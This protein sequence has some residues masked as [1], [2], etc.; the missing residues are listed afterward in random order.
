MDSDAG[1]AET[2]LASARWPPDDPSA[3]QHVPQMSPIELRT[4][5]LRVGPSTID[6]GKMV[7]HLGNW[8]RTIWKLQLSGFHV[9]RRRLNLGRCQ[10]SISISPLQLKMKRCQPPISIFI[11]PVGRC[12][13]EGSWT[14]TI[15]L[16]PFQ[17]SVTDLRRQSL[18][19]SISTR[20]PF[21]RSTH[22]TR[23][24]YYFE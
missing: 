21:S 6:W 12:R 14:S 1:A 15:Q 11:A 2:Q 4:L 18:S 13:F 23:H 20:V 10:F 7:L 3:T 16:S 22:S 8:S 17:L 5:D 19:R 24:D 9:G